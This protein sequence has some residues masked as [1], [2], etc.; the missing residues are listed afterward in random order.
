MFEAALVS[1]PNKK[2]IKI[3]DESA[4]F[5]SPLDAQAQ[6][7]FYQIRIYVEMTSGTE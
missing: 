1:N 3:Y 5:T 6:I 4:Y 2:P 7:G